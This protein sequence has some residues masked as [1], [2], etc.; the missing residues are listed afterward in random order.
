MDAIS[1]VS[2]SKDRL[3]F[4]IK[5]PKLN[6]ALHTRLEVFV[7]DLGAG[8]AE[9]VHLTPHSHGAISGL[10]FS[11]DG[12]QLA[13]LEQ[14]EDGYESDRNVLTVQSF[15]DG[16]KPGKQVRW[17]EQW[18]RSPKEVVWSHDGESVYLVAEHHGSTLPYHLTHPNHLPTPLLFNG[19]TTSVTVLGHDSLLLGLTSLTSPLDTFKLTVSAPGNNDGDK[20]PRSR[21]QRLTDW[22]SAHLAGRLDAHGGEPFW[23]TGAEGW[24][25]M[26]WVVK[27]RGWSLKAAK[28]GKKWPLAFLIHGGPQGAWVDSWSTRWNPALFAAQGYFVVAVNPT[29]S[30]GYGQEFTDRIKQQWGGR[31]CQKHHDPS[32]RDWLTAPGPFKDLLAGYHAALN[33]FPEVSHGQKYT[34]AFR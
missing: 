33:E 13:W 19:S 7:M 8:H 32:G 21:L 11:P 2:L 28:A 31:E 12:K 3:A 24:D 34:T 17:T 10:T 25:V 23:F 16:G 15:H 14:A 30:T 6:P 27:P 4:V 26:A 5:D 22:S 18:D 9:P 1:Q 20:L 29:G